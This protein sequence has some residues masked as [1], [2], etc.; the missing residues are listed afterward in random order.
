MKVWDFYFDTI[1]FFNKEF[2]I[3]IPF[4]YYVSK[5]KFSEVYQPFSS[6]VIL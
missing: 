2:E 3:A 4:A 6:Q 1:N 5:S